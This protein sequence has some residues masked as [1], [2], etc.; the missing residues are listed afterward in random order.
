MNI[1]RTTSLGG[2]DAAAALGLSPWKT[3]YQLWLEKKGQ[4]E[5]QVDSEPMYWGRALEDAVIRRFERDTQQTV[6][7]RQMRF[8][9]G[10]RSVTVDGV[11]LSGALV[12]AKT[13]YSTEGFGPD[14]SDEIPQHYMIQV[15]HNLDLTKL[16]ICHMPVLFHGSEYRCFTIEADAELQ[17]LILEG[18]SRFW[19]LVTT[20]TPPEPQSLDDV[21]HRYRQSEE[22]PIQA[23]DTIAMKASSLKVIKERMKSMEVEHDALLAELMAYMK[24]ADVLEF[25]GVKL[26]TWKTGKGQTR[27]NAKAFQER[28]PDVYKEFLVTGE[29]IRRFLIK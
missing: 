14:G 20:N 23:T 29:P 6:G 27:F 9:N 3:A 5:L 10:F 22:T 24:T 17:A 15:Q 19:N 8:E 18:E 4:G 7:D 25:D 26:A 16:S 2:S 12:E 13:A 11:D 28:H 1:D 21:R